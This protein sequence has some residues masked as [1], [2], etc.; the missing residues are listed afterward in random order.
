MSEPEGLALLL[1]EPDARDQLI[2]W[3]RRRSV[4]A[5]SKEFGRLVTGKRGPNRNGGLLLS[6]IFWLTHL[7]RA[8]RDVVMIDDLAWL[9]RTRDEWSADVGMGART[10]ERMLNLLT[11]K[12]LI[13][14]QLRVSNLHEHRGAVVNHMRPNSP[15]IMAGLV[16]L[17]SEKQDRTPGQRDG[18]SSPPESPGGAFFLALPV[19]ETVTPPSAFRGGVEPP[20][21]APLTLEREVHKRVNIR[22]ERPADDD[23]LVA[24]LVSD[25]MAAGVKPESRV[26]QLVA[27]RPLDDSRRILE[28]FAAS[29]AGQ[30]GPGYLVRALQE[31]YG[32]EAEDCELVSATTPT[33][34]EI[35]ATQGAE[36]ER[37]AYMQAQTERVR[38]IL[39]AR[40]ARGEVVDP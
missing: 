38:E 39:A 34:E 21:A 9:V 8:R 1:D 3:A 4:V 16:A 22:E 29:K 18:G 32:L 28:W 37:L 20:N 23:A 27:L 26:R 14:R 15:L 10:V 6:Q 36:R 11:E 19:P 12:C 33:A 2:G 30:A 7:A 31:G 25:L 5:Y 17:E 35:V 40:R 13:L 24:C